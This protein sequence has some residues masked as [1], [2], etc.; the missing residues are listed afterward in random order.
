MGAMVCMFNWVN[1][2]NIVNMVDMADMI[3]M[4]K[5]TNYLAKLFDL[6]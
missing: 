6:S 4:V 5:G 3:N 2:V 1:M